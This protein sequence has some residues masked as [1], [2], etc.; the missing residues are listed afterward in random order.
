MSTHDDLEVCLS[1]TS[2]EGGMLGSYRQFDPIY[3]YTSPQGL[4]GILQDKSPVLWFSQFNSL[5]DTTEGIHAVDVFQYVCK[6][7][8][9]EGEISDVFYQEIC[10]VI[11]SSSELF[12]YSNQSSVS[13]DSPTKPLNDLKISEAQKYI[14]CFS[15][16]SDSLPMWNY[17]SQNN[18]YEGYNIG[19]SFV[20]IM[21]RG[22]L[23]C[24]GIGYQFGLFSVIYNDNEKRTIIRNKI[25]QL[26]AFVEDQ[27]DEETV[28]K[29]K[30]ILA[31]YLKDL[32]LKFKHSCFQHENEVRAILTV[33]KDSRLFPIKYRNKAG[34]I[35]P[36]IEY[37]LPKQII[38]GITVGPL[39]NGTMA[40]ENIKQ[41]A[42]DRGYSFCIDNIHSSSIP[43]RY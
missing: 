33:P 43:I 23:D 5:N 4:I 42:R 40:T 24:Y 39:I 35:I 32:S 25:K 38:S 2:I 16:D 1:T 36:Y 21:Q 30:N 14:C 12:L 41:F 18:K 6:K 26:Y 37:P 17:Y 3:H 28:H 10:N 7:M 31:F 19:F 29:I 8:L 34:Y 11:P 22:L 20:S 9:E 27:N 15:K 13:T